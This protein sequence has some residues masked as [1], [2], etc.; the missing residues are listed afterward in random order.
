MRPRWCRD[1]ESAGAVGKLDYVPPDG[2][3]AGRNKQVDESPS[4]TSQS[5]CPKIPAAGPVLFPDLPGCATHA[6][7]HEAQW[8]AAEAADLHL[9]SMRSAGMPVLLSRSHRPIDVGQGVGAFD[10]GGM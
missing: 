10:H 5:S 1:A 8:M 6:T 2:N 3:L 4:T 9:A 7:V